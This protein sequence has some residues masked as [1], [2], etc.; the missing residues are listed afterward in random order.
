MPIHLQMHTTQDMVDA[1]FF[2]GKYEFEDDAI[3]HMKLDIET[4]SKRDLK[5]HSKLWNW[6]KPLIS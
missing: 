6:H 5:H 2:A 4:G 1:P 3:V